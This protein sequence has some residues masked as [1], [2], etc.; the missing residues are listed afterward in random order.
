MTTL[1][2]VGLGRMGASLA[3]ALGTEGVSVH[4]F[5]T[6]P[7]ARA[8]AAAAGVTV[9]ESLGSLAAASGLV[10]TSLPTTEAVRDAVS[11]LAAVVRPGA[12]VVETS[13]CGPDL[14][15]ELAALLTA[16]GSAFVDAPVSRKAP[17]MT[18]LVGGAP[19]VL[20]EAGP[21]LERVSREI[22]YCGA[23][24]G[25]YRVKLLNQFLKYARFLVASEALAFADTAGLD[26]GAVIRG[27]ASGT[28]AEPGL[29]TAEELVQGDLEAVAR[30]APLGTIVKDV[31]L[32]RRM[33]ADVGFSSPSFDALEEFF[34][35]AGATDLIDLPY[36]E[37]ARLLDAF[38]TQSRK[39]A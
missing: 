39:D 8:T 28:G 32:A 24:G 15:E 36:P 18:L 17:E 34:L 2:I 31:E 20:G 19:G 10:V 29:A 21:L 22:I 26:L 23:L 16:A 27:L 35:A 38:R 14:A 13:T 25:G 6:D 33:F 3:R 9:H 37:A 12:L 4:G 11:S 1:A 7:G 5:D 30:H